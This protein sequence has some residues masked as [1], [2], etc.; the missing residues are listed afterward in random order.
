MYTIY[1]QMPKE[2]Y[3]H[4]ETMIVLGPEYFNFSQMEKLK[5]FHNHIWIKKNLQ[6]V[7]NGHFGKNE[8]Q[9]KHPSKIWYIR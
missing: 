8:S 1:N 3:R 6:T 9:K 4:S 7:L 2:H 5:V